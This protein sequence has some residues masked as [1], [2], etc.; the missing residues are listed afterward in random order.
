[1]APFTPDLLPAAYRSEL[2]KLSESGRRAWMEQRLRGQTDH[3]FLANELM[4]YDFQPNPHEALF[5]ELLQ[6][7]PAQNTPLFQLGS[8]CKCRPQYR[9]ACKKCNGTG[10]NRRKKRM[11]QW[12]RGLFKTSAIIVEIVQ[13]ILNYP[14]IR[15]LFL[16]GNLKLGKRQLARVKRVFEQ[17]SAKFR[18]LYPEFCAAPGRKLPDSTPDGFT[19]PCRTAAQFAEPTFCISSA[20]SVKSGT[21]Y[22]VIFV[23]DLVNDQNFR[24]A[25][26]LES[27]WE[28]YLAVIP[29]LEPAGFLY[30]TGTPYAFGDTY[31]RIKEAADKEEAETGSSVWEF[32]I[33][34]AWCKLCKTC[35]HPDLRHNSDLSYT[36]PPCTMEDCACKCFVDS[37]EKQVLFPIAITR[38]GRQVG[39]TVEMLEA[40]QREDPGF[41]ALQYLCQRIA[42]EEQRYTPELIAR[43]TFWHLNVIPPQAGTFMVGD[44]SY[45]GDD[46]RDRSVLY[47]VRVWMGVLWV[48]HCIAGN[49]DSDEAMTNVL[50]AIMQHRPQAVWLER[51]NGWE[52][53]NN[54]LMAKAAQHGLLQLPVEWRKLD[55]KT[56]AKTIR[57]GVP[58]SWMKDRKLWL[59]AG[60]PWYDKL[61]KQLLKWPKIPHH[62]DEGDCLGH[63]C[64]VPH[65]AHGIPAPLPAGGMQDRIRKMHRDAAENAGMQGFNPGGTGSG[66]CSG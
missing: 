1:M 57:I 37:G 30:I 33:K 4:G 58:L 44:L 63:A 52:A 62:D 6:K 60:M 22:D 31:E 10:I 8:P 43:Q 48:Y 34:A 47:L 2:E 16:T 17:P 42:K 19:V 26:L 55:R 5:R 36:S 53:Y 11:I 54:I 61:I 39:H 56:N 40:I 18:Q 65:G 46:K 51:F 45:I 14:N 59:F 66:V 50:L 21:H 32:S 12:P 29:L 38:D 3:L 49:W 27:A 13:L 7:D 20:K 15:I 41:F 23:D 64:E 9:E 35:G 24:S 25:K 28:D